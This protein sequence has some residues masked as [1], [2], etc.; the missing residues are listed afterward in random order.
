MPQEI[1]PQARRQTSAAVQIP[2]RSLGATR[3]QAVFDEP[4]L[5]SDG[6]ALLLREAAEVNGIVDAMAALCRRHSPTFRTLHCANAPK[7]RPQYPG[8]ELRRS[9]SCRMN[10]TG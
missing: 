1:L 6:G 2:L 4:D 5:S 8:D 3:V 10:Q 9:E 7:E